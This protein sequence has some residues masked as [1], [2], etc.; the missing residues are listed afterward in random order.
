MDMRCV[1]ECV[2]VWEGPTTN[3]M[4][5]IPFLSF[6]PSCPKK[7]KGGGSL[8]SLSLLDTHATGQRHT[9]AS[10]TSGWSCS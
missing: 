7:E 9:P 6:L 5:R 2:S 1:W 10:D 3:T 8:S 4:V